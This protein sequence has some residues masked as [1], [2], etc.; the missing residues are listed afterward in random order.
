MPM[1]IPHSRLMTAAATLLAV[2][3]PFVGIA[4]IQ[5]SGF[6]SLAVV[7][8][9]T[10]S[11]G[12]TIS[13]G[14]VPYSDPG[15]TVEIDGHAGSQSQVRVGDVVTAYGHGG[16]GD[17]PDVI[18]RLILNHAVRATVESVDAA[19]GTFSAAGQTIHVN[20]QTALD[21]TLTLIGLSALLPGAKVQVSGWADSAGDIV[22]SRIDVLALAGT[23]EVS[24]QLSSLD[25]ARQRFKINQLTVDFSHSEVEGV[26]QEGADVL[27][28]GA[29][30]DKTGALVAQQVQLVQ[31]LQVSAGQKGRLDGIVTSLTSASEFEINGQPVQVTSATKMDLHGA[32][33]LNAHV[34]VDG[35]FNSSGVLVVSKLQTGK[36]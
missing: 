13:V 8:P 11:G 12:G 7:A 23:T 3:I 10:A 19:G 34:K 22:A 36:K 21:P 18:E 15:A 27:V 29:S 24:G 1:N 30:F 2:C 25:A 17:N 6:R 31:P 14:G 28:G 32:V 5:G 9:V 26:L 35:V 16:N 20:A 33:A 4:G